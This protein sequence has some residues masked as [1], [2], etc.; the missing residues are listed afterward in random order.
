M[1]LEELAPPGWEDA[2]NYVC[3]RDMIYGTAV[4]KV[5]AVVKPQIDRTAATPS[6]IIVGEH[7][8]TPLIVQEQSEMPA[9]TSWPGSSQMRLGSE[10][11]Q[12]HKF[13]PVLSPGA[14]TDSMQIQD[15]NLVELVS[16]NPCMKHP[17]LITI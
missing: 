2:A 11:P 6:P 14:A 13:I 15:A 12:S 4:L 9:V 8:Q 5:P 16:F 3:E 10:N 7:M 17:Q 1:S